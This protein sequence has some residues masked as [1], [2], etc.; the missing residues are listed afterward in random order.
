MSLIKNVSEEVF[1]D[2]KEAVTIKKYVYIVKHLKRDDECVVMYANSFHQAKQAASNF[3]RWVI[4]RYPLNT[5]PS[6]FNRREAWYCDLVIGKVFVPAGT[7]FT[8]PRGM[9][10]FKNV[11]REK[12]LAANDSSNKTN[13]ERKLGKVID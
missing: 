2:L 12:K 7:L 10:T 9:V 13:N 3:E 11:L 4:E 1:A 5:Y 8:P 6:P